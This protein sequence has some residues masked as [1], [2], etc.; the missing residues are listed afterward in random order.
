MSF[1]LPLADPHQRR[2]TCGPLM[3]TRIGSALA[4]HLRLWLCLRECQST[5]PCLSVECDRS[6]AQEEP[7]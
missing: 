7:S 2:S 6:G 1:F 5:Q 3:L 4:C